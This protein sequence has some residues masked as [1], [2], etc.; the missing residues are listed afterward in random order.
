VRARVS[1]GAA[2]RARL[3]RP[4]RLRLE[5]QVAVR[6]VRTPSVTQ[7]RLWVRAA[8]ARPAEVTVRIVGR[9]EARL[10]N[11]RYRG[12]ND[13]ANVLS[14]PYGLS[15]GTLRGDVVLCAPVIRREAREQGKT[16]EAHFA[17]MTVHGM[18]HLQGHD[19]AKPRDA[20]RME[21]RERKLLS[22]LGYP[23]PYES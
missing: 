3:R 12:R 13:A 10:L 20:A 22:K 14:F 6:G 11:R 15:N 4:R 19:H 2:R 16:L 7:V 8:L 21:A 9:S 1:P 5:L 17:H 18:L 23:D